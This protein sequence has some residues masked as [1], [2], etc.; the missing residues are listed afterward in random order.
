MLTHFFFTMT[1]H[2]RYLSSHRMAD[3]KT[4]LKMVSWGHRGGGWWQGPSH[5]LTLAQG[6]ARAQETAG[7]LLGVS[8]GLL[9]KRVLTSHSLPSSQPSLRSKTRP[10]TAALRGREGWFPLLVPPPG[11][12]HTHLP[13][14]S[15]GVDGGCGRTVGLGEENQGSSGCSGQ[16]SGVEED[17]AARPAWGLF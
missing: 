4:D 6:E 14:A 13:E 15:S 1:L 7:L 8:H 11:H 3:E 12:T 5:H 2:G 16:G 9:G 17:G 10:S